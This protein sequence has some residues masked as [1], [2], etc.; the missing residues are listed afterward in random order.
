M[1]DTAKTFGEQ[2]HIEAFS[3]LDIFIETNQVIEQLDHV[4]QEEGK[5]CNNY[6]MNNPQEIKLNTLRSQAIDS[7]L[8]WCNT[9]K[10]KLQ[11]SGSQLEFYLKLQLMMQLIRNNKATEAV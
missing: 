6:L 7:A 3:N 8:N 9:Y 5:H 11:N 2:T 1:F 4:I 10:T